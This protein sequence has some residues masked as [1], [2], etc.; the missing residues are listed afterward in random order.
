MTSSISKVGLGRHNFG[1]GRPALTGGA[2]CAALDLDRCLPRDSRCTTHSVPRAAASRGESTGWHGAGVEVGSASRLA[3]LAANHRRASQMLVMLCTLFSFLA[4][5]ATAAQAFQTHVLDGAHSPFAGAPGDTK[6]EQ[7]IGVAVDN[8]SGP[9]AGDVYITSAIGNVQRFNENGEPAPFTAS[10]P[11]I[12]GNLLTG[13]PETHFATPLWIA[14]DPSGPKAGNFYV[15]D[16]YGNYVVDEFDETGKYLGQFTFP[17]FFPSGVVI[18]PDHGP[19]GYLYAT[20]RNNF[21]VEQF[22]LKTRELISQFPANIGVQIDS[23]AVNSA[24]DLFVVDQENTITEYN[25]SSE[26]PGENLGVLDA[27]GSS[28]V[29]IDPSN[30]DIYTYDNSGFHHFTSTKEPLETFGLGEV[31]RSYGLSV[32]KVTHSVYAAEYNENDA[33]I[34]KTGPTLPNTVTEA[35]TEIR[36]TTAT[37]NGHVDP[38]SA[39]GGGEIESCKFEYGPTEAYGQEHHVRWRRQS[40]AQ[41]RSM[42]NSRGWVG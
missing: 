12:T 8:S 3:A 37:L 16:A 9:A 29:A 24:G 10:S 39:D 38:D 15:A 35:A 20:D 6:T 31:G 28:A 42:L 13:T 5:T 33:V 32:N 4:L 40:K 30:G 26:P 2:Q 21:H 25:P 1:F 14:V 22:D 41:P 11:R 17:N 19:N 36:H 18:D 34:F 27:N 7:P 23:L